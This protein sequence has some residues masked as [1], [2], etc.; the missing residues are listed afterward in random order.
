MVFKLLLQNQMVNGIK[1]TVMVKG[2]VAVVN[3]WTSVTF[4]HR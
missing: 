2:T 1:K 4:Q 3:S